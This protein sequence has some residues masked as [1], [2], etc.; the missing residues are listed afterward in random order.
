[1]DPTQAQLIGLAPFGVVTSQQ[2]NSFSQADPFGG[3]V[4]GYMSRQAARYVCKKLTGAES[5]QRECVKVGGSKA[6][7]NKVDSNDEGTQRLERVPNLNIRVQGLFQAAPRKASAPEQDSGEDQSFIASRKSFDIEA[8]MWY[9][10]PLP[11][12]GNSTVLWWGPYLAY[13]GST[14]MD[15]NEL[16]DEAVNKDTDGAAANLDTSRVS[17][18]NDMDRYYEAGLIFNYYRPDAADSN[19][20]VQAILAYGNYEALG[21][22]VNGHDTRKR[23]IGKLRVFPT[24]LNRSF[25]EKSVAAPMFGVDLNAGRGEDHVKFFVGMTF[26][27]SKLISGLK[28]KPPAE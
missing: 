7:S 14:V 25:F 2:A 26:N 23:F 4:V 28:G 15:R 1:L 9:E 27:I 18:T 12:S 3:F 16:R 10:M 5:W 22:L 13:G 20:Y 6:F 24:G 17:T 19:L 11:F 8:H 21:G